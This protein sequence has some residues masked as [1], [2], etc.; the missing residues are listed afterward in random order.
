MGSAQNTPHPARAD[1]GTVTLRFAGRKRERRPRLLVRW[2]WTRA[3]WALVARLWTVGA[4]SPN[5]RP[6]RNLDGRSEWNSQA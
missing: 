5:S 2:R 3:H 1:A 6:S 4:W